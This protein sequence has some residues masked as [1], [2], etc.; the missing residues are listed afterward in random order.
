VT[1][2]LPRIGTE[3]FDGSRLSRTGTW[4]VAFLADWCPFCR[5][6]EA[7]IVRLTTSPTFGVV[8]ADV[9]PPTSPLWDRFDL[10]VVPTVVVF[11]DGRPIYRAD[12]IPGVGLG[13]DAVAAIEKAADG[14]GGATAARTIRRGID[15]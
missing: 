7:E 1:V 9:T 8:V 14:A 2:A 6:F 15:S 5:E 13:S 12:G 3:A 4:A 11:R 10:E